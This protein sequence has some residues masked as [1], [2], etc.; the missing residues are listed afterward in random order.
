MR[1][2][3]SAARRRAWSAEDDPMAANRKRM[4]PGSCRG[5]Q[6]NNRPGRSVDLQPARV[7]ARR[8][9]AEFNPAFTCYALAR[10]RIGIGHRAGERGAARRQRPAQ[11]GIRQA[12]GKHHRRAARSAYGP[13][14]LQPVQHRGLTLRSASGIGMRRGLDCAVIAA[15]ALQT[16]GREINQQRVFA[17]ARPYAAYGPRGKPAAG[18]RRNRAAP[19]RDACAVRVRGA[20]GA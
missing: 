18:G 12:V 13:A 3:I 17:I 7:P 9:G 14:V 5:R 19:A 11:G 4:P 10:A 15:D 1:A 2:R 6:P 8:N 20:G 16:F